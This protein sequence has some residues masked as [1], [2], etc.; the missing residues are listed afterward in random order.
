MTTENQAAK[1]VTTEDGKLWGRWAALAHCKDGELRQFYKAGNLRDAAEDMDL[2]TGG[3]W[4]CTLCYGE[5]HPLV[6][7]GKIAAGTVRSA[8]KASV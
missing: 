5:D 8:R 3:G 2:V 1:I 7:S 4:D 6:R